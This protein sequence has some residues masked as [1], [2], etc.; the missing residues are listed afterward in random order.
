LV[1]SITT[2]EVEVE[3]VK[4]LLDLTEETH[5][6]GTTTGDAHE[7]GTATVAGTETQFDVATD[8]I[9]EAGTETTA[10]DGTDDGTFE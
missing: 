2:A 4:T 7:V 8:V 3:I 1:K 9:T 10:E 6:V 5:V